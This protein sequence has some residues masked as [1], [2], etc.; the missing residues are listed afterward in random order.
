MPCEILLCVVEK[1]CKLHSLFLV[2][3]LSKWWLLQPFKF[4]TEV[5]IGREVCTYLIQS[6]SVSSERDTEA[7]FQMTTQAEKNKTSFEAKQSERY[8]DKIEALFSRHLIKFVTR[9]LQALNCCCLFL[10]FSGAHHPAP[11]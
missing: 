3:I 5:K 4:I 8:K 9:I 7:D 6:K 1:N 2:C 10:L 11:R